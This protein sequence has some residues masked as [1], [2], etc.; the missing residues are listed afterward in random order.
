[1]RVET[2]EAVIVPVLDEDESGSGTFEAILSAPTKDRDGDT[3]LPGEWKQPLPDHI[4]VDIDHEMKVAGTI[5]SA[6]PWLDSE[7]NLR[8]SGRFASTARAQEV[9][10]L[11]RDRHI[12][13]TSVAFLTEKSTKAGGTGIVRELL[14]AALVAVPSNREAVILSAKH[15]AAK[16][17]AR[18]SSADLDRIQA[19]H[20]E[21]HALGAT[22]TGA[23]VEEVD[24]SDAESKGLDEAIW[25]AFLATQGGTH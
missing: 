25:T 4:T 23:D 12:R 11:V 8:I 13:T 22:C 19:I 17:G 7:G 2:K 20:D 9:R 14:N 24:T 1:M 5:G 15:F 6:R 10:S 3:L 18:N 21:A 16:A